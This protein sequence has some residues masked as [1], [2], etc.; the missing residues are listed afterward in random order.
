MTL[1]NN[2]T[3]FIYLKDKQKADMGLP[4]SSFA[5]Q[6]NGESQDVDMPEVS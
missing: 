3:N 2:N 4:S 6:E 1:K 5:P